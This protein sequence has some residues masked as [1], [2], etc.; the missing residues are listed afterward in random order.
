MKRKFSVITVLLFVVLLQA[1]ATAMTPHEAELNNADNLFKAGKYDHAI[2][3]YKMLLQKNPGSDIA[4]DAQFAIAYTLV[5][6]DNP[7]INYPLAM[8]EFKRFLTLY[9]K[10]SR[11]EE[12]Q[13]WYKVLKT[14]YDTKGENNALYK[15]IQQLKQ[16]DIQRE[17]SIH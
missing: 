8:V 1:C 5:Y 14:L 17:R 7:N 15:K 9:P 12:A 6:Y 3:A 16:L 2:A 4:A 10:D 11:H 13:N